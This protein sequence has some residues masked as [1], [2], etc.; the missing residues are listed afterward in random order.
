MVPGVE[1]C[2]L[3]LQAPHFGALEMERGPGLTKLR[4]G[5]QKSWKPFSCCEES[6]KKK[7][8][9]LGSHQ[10]TKWDLREERAGRV[11]TT[12]DM[13]LGLRVQELCRVRG[14]R[15]EQIQ[16]HGLNEYWLVT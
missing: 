12:Q 10:A 15:S 9:C 14:P 3:G 7:K 5:R 2:H 13:S 6:K 8:R 1:K 11:I 4:G 16:G